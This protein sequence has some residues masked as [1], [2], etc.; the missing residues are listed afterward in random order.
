MEN[1]VSTD[2][3]AEAENNSPIAGPSMEEMEQQAEQLISFYQQEADLPSFFMK[4][5]PEKKKEIRRFERL[6]SEEVL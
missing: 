1:F 2:V 4:R 5:Q 3:F 6:T